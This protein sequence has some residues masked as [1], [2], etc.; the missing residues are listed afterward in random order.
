VLLIPG[1]DLLGEIRVDE[2]AA[3]VVSS[4]QKMDELKKKGSLERVGMGL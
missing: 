1:E 2:S 3:M 4:S